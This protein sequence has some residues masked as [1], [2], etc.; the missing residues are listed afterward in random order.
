MISINT[1]LL[2]LLAINFLSLLFLAK[3]VRSIL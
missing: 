3:K 2:V 1:I